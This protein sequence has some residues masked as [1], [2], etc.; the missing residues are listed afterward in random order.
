MILH[1]TGRLGFLSYLYEKRH[2]IA[3]AVGLTSDM[4]IA[5]CD[6][7]YDFETGLKIQTADESDKGLPSRTF[8]TREINLFLEMSL[9]VPKPQFT[10]LQQPDAPPF[11]DAYYEG[12]LKDIFHPPA[13]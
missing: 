8:A 1:C 4:P 7:N 9:V 11:V 13:A 3:Y 5:M 6:S 10:L 12:P 2:S